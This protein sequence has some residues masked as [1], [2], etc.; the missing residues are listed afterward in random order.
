MASVW[1]WEKSRDKKYSLTEWIFVG[2]RWTPADRDKKIS[3]AGHLPHG[4]T[5]RKTSSCFL[6][7]AGGKTRSIKETWLTT[8]WEGEKLFSLS[9][10]R[11][12]STT[13]SLFLAFCALARTPNKLR[14]HEKLVVWIYFLT[15]VLDEITVKA[16]RERSSLLS[17]SAN[18]FWALCGRLKSWKGKIN[19]FQTPDTGCWAA[20]PL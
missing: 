1:K 10:H 2:A 17:E 4:N 6:A 11:K 13:L 7:C 19:H 12:H 18:G 9:S 8:R 20:Q 16:F 15:L 5:A 14:Q 3:P